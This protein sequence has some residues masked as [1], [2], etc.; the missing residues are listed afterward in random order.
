MSYTKFRVS[1]TSLQLMTNDELDKHI[2]GVK[3]E[4]NRLK[5][6]TYEK[7]GALTILCNRLIAFK[8]KTAELKVTDHAVVEYFED[9]YNMNI[10][11]I[12]NE[13][14]DKVSQ[15]T[16]INERVIHK[17]VTYIVKNGTVITVYKGVKPNE[18]K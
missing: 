13:I 8:E 2:Q 11:H 10:D 6:D 7:I 4:V 18:S 3:S 17:D 1:D 16:K 15:G 12:R 14:L 5:K 9:V